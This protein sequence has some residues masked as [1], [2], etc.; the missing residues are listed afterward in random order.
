RLTRASFRGF[1]SLHVLGTAPLVR[2]VALNGLRQTWACPRH[3]D[4]T[5]RFL[6]FRQTSYGEVASGRGHSTRDSRSW[7]ACFR[8]HSRDGR[9]LILVLVA[10]GESLQEP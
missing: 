7:K 4:V 8:S 6:A 1:A 2:E 9:L 10:C 5:P 3:A